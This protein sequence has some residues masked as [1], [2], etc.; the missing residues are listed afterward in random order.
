MT[1]IDAYHLTLS[2]ILELKENGIN[3]EII[4]TKSRIDKKLIERFNQPERIPPEKW[5]SVS[6]KI[7]NHMDAVKIHEMANYLGMCGIR[8]D[9]G[10]CLN[11]RD[12]EL[13][14]SFKYVKGEDNLDWKD[15]REIVEDLISVMFKKVSENYTEDDINSCKL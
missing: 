15:D 14:W 9:T 1:P 4:P 2:K 12:W 7:K 3:V 13:D 11:C 5:V 8:F 10:G 6:F